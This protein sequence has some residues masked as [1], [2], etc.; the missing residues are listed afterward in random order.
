MYQ[1]L[2]YYLVVLL[3]YVTYEPLPQ[4]GF[5]LWGE[6]V[7]GLVLI[8]CY[9]AWARM[10]FKRLYARTQTGSSGS[11]SIRF[12]K[13]QH[14]LSLLAL[15]FYGLDVYGLSFKEL[16]HTLPLA[17]R[18]SAV[19]GIMGLAFFSLYLILLWSESFRIYSYLYSTRLSRRRFVWS[20]ISF[21]LPIIL[22]FLLLSL[23]TDLV[24][25][26]PHEGLRG[27]L[28]SPAG[29]LTSVLIFV[30]LLMVIFPA[31]IRP[32]WRLT[33]LPPGHERDIIETYCRKH[34]FTYRE[35]MLWPLYEGE[36]LTAGV[37]GLIKRYRY[38]LVTRSL[39]RIL[40]DEELEAVIGHEFGH[41]KLR[42]LRYYLFFFIGYIIV[43]YTF[44]ELFKYWLIY[45]GLIFK[46]DVASEELPT[47]FMLIINSPWVIMLIVYFRFILGAF[48]RNFERQADLF[49]FRLNGTVKGLV[50]SLEKIA[51]YSGQSRNVPSWHH[52]SVAQRVEYLNRSEANPSMVEGHFKKVRRM[53][54]GYVAVFL[55][56]VVGGNYILPVGPADQERLSIQ[57]LQKII[58][59]NPSQPQPY[60]ILA[61]FYFES[62]NVDKAIEYW[63]RVQAIVPDNPEIL[64][65]LAWALITRPDAS[66]ENK[67]RGLELALQAIRIKQAAHIWDT[68]AEALY[69]NGRYEEALQAIDRAIET[70]GAQ[71]DPKYLLDQKEKILKAVNP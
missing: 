39:L 60:Q 44:D 53:L 6:I 55:V 12:Q 42:H 8:L 3:I 51:F 29:D 26:L 16:F 33:P 41:V 65:N 14:R 18:S 45:S 54:I 38:I 58:K 24:T 69:V 52:Y 46:F 57:K 49:S 7:P 37:M 56:I 70:A 31:V 40:D 19:S 35:I 28:E 43:A 62:G 68:L 9:W 5:S 50:S 71:V 25:L 23:F 59:E 32:L 20:Q 34:G 22:P 15:A 11:I 10:S 13:L 66:A 2:V 36:G 67:A 1:N 47:V 4:A 27:W 63:E 21:N 61:N 17:A 64:N 48:M 30:G